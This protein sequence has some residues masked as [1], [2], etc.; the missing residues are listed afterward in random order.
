MADSA[1]T[2]LLQMP[3]LRPNIPLESSRY[4]GLVWF[5]RDHV[6]EAWFNDHFIMSIDLLETHFAKKDRMKSLKIS[7]LWCGPV[8]MDI[9]MEHFIRA[10]MMKQC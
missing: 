10:Q 1:P 5:L 7:D 6:F 3:V 4:P 2:G 9:E 8:V